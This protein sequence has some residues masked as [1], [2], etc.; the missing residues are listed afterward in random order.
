MSCPSEVTTERLRLRRPRHSDV[1]SIFHTYA[2]DEQVCYYLGWPTHTSLAD[3]ESFLEIADAEWQTHGGGPYLILHRD[4]GELV[5]ST[6][7]GFEPNGTVSTG[8][9]IA[10]P[11]WGKGMAT[12]ALQAILKIATDTGI[13]SLHAC[14]HPDHRASQRVVEKCGFQLDRSVDCEF[15]FPNHETGA[16][17]PALYYS[18]ATGRAK[19]VRESDAADVAG[20]RTLY[21]LAFPDEDLLA[22]V[23]D[24]LDTPTG[25]LSLVADV[26]AKIAGH[27]VFSNCGVAGTDIEASLLGPLA[28]A[29][30]RQKQGIGT[31]LIRAGLRQLEDDAV[32]LV[33]VLGDPA[34]YGRFGFAEETRIEPPFPL[35]TEWHSAWQSLQLG[36]STK[37]GSAKLVVPEPWRK[38]EL[39]AP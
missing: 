5:G 32:G 27:L 1:Q 9:V 21:P 16:P 31:A 2:S 23:G 22:L 10:R 28:V 7:I 11:Y 35:P 38:P 19:Y 37:P 39:W 4:S 14:V 25:C 36:K 12:E 30:E 3:T 24:L 6:G 18:I 8:Y 33:C 26:D 29:P 34:Y 17:Q 13:P 20:I 15:V